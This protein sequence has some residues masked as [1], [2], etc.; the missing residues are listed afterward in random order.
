M[1]NWCFSR[2]LGQAWPNPGIL[3]LKV[4]LKP[5]PA[6]LGSALLAKGWRQVALLWWN[7]LDRDSWSSCLAIEVPGGT[8]RVSSSDV[9][10]VSYLE[11]TRLCRYQCVATN[12]KMPRGCKIQNWNEN[13]VHLRKGEVCTARSYAWLQNKLHIKK[14]VTALHLLPFSLQS[15]WFCDLCESTTK[16]CPLNLNL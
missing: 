15:L 4:G 5:N 11:E 10:T 7:S 12:D 13:T 2:A 1:L 14:T 6:A 16:W 8:T 3:K 9:Y